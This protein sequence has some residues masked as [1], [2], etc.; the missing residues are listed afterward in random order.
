MIRVLTDS[1]TQRS[2]VPSEYR[3]SF[4][5]QAQPH[6]ERLAAFQLHMGKP[7]RALETLERFRARISG[8]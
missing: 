8:S 2:Y 6:Y 3:A 1:E 7:D 4:S 5:D